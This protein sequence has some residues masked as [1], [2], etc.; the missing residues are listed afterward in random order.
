M[1]NTQS[2]KTVFLI[3]LLVAT[4]IL[5]LS[6]IDAYAEME[7]DKN[8]TDNLQTVNIE[9]LKTLE[10]PRTPLSEENLKK[11]KYLHET[12]AEVDDAPLAVWI[13]DFERDLFVE[14]SIDLWMYMTEIY[15]STV[16]TFP[17]ELAYKKEIFKV[18][19][20]ASVAEDET[21]VSAGYELL[22][23]A[24]VKSILEKYRSNSEK[25]K[26]RPIPVIKF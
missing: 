10:L 1:K 17:D 2:P 26:I 24:E 4:S 25:G 19:I 23:E 11:V 15:T 8:K 3:S 18:I 7:R 6:L 14:D 13:E 21:V 9:N 12:F 20:G 5:V 16:P 22:S